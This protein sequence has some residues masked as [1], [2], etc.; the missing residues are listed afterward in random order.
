MAISSPCKPEGSGER[1]IQELQRQIYLTSIQFKTANMPMLF[2]P[3]TTRI[4]NLCSEEEIRCVFDDND[5]Y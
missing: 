3:L 1:L 4:H 2:R 5:I